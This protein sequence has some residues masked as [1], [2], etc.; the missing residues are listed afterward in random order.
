[1]TIKVKFD[2]ILGRLR[3][4]DG[5]G[6]T[7]TPPTPSF[8]QTTT[9]TANQTYLADAVTFPGMTV[10]VR[11]RLDGTLVDADNT[12]QGWTHVSTGVYQRAL[13]QPGTV[14]SQ[15]W[16]HTTSASSIYGQRTLSVTSPARSCLPVYPAYWGIY[17]SN[18]AAGDITTVVASLK[19]QHRQTANLPQTTVEVPNPTGSSCWLWIVTKGTATAQPA[20]TPGINMMENP[21]DGKNFVSPMP[22]A[23]WNLTGYKAYVSMQSAKAGA[24][25]GN[26]ILTINLS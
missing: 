24:S 22:G 6:G 5:D 7:P 10:E 21:V 16:Q 23:N 25:F 1:M 3:E 19:D 9:P 12:P 26:V 14:P 8:T 2:R 11:L 17:P 13:S 4:K 18:D 15:T 20:P